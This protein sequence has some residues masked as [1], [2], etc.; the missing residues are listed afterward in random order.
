M[1]IALKRE[2]VQEG[3]VIDQRLKTA[4][5]RLNIKDEDKRN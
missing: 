1:I 4:D 3:W 5:Q 2:N